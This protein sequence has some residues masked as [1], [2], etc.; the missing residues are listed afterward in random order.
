MPAEKLDETLKEGRLAGRSALRLLLVRLWAAFV[1]P[2]FLF[3]PSPSFAEISMDIKEAIALTLEN[4]SELRSLRQE[5]VKADAFR[6]QAE[7]AFLPEAAFNAYI[8]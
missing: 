7:G 5:M 4:N 1:L 8:D 2:V 6:L 3:I